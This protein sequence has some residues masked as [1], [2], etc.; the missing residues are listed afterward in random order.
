VLGIGWSKLLD[1]TL[2]PSPTK[3]FASNNQDPTLMIFNYY[4]MVSWGSKVGTL[5]LC[6]GLLTLVGLGTWDM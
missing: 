2:N 1:P 6:W 3:I 5:P 4:L